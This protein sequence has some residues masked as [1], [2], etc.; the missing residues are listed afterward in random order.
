MVLHFWLLYKE[1]GT[2]LL[3]VKEAQHVV[4]SLHCS[5]LI[6]LHTV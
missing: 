4:A 2:V 3:V 5:R 6:K 1:G